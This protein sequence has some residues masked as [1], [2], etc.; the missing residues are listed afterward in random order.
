MPNLERAFRE[1]SYD[2][3]Q[4][5]LNHYKKLDNNNNR[6]TAIINTSEGGAK[7]VKADNKVK[8]WSD[9]TMDNPEIAKFFND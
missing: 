6:N 5:K 7:E 9:V 1:W 2:S 4:E 3:M 8:S